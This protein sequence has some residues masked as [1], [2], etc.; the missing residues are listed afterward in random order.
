[1]WWGGGE[2]PIKKKQFLGALRTGRGRITMKEY[3]MKCDI[4]SSICRHSFSE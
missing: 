2:R 1:M 3:L 4:G